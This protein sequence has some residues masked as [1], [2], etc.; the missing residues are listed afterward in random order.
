MHLQRSSNETLASARNRE[1]IKKQGKRNHNAYCPCAWPCGDVNELH[2]QHEHLQLCPRLHVQH[3]TGP[4]RTLP[5]EKAE[6]RWWV[7]RAGNQEK[8]SSWFLLHCHRTV[9]A[10]GFGC[11]YWVIAR[12]PL[13]AWQSHKDKAHPNATAGGAATPY[14]MSKTV[15]RGE[16]WY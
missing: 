11:V 9:E 8:E 7:S 15:R 14:T 10:S 5:A 6:E 2:P 4:P 3:V 1:S 13:L 12:A 16:T